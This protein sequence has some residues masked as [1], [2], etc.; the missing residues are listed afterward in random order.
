MPD[1]DQSSAFD[2]AP[3]AAAF[4]ASIDAVDSDAA[5]SRAAV[6]A[7][8]SAAGGGLRVVERRPLGEL[9]HVFSHIR[10][11]MRVERLVVQVGWC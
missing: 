11:T 3:T 1:P 5:D 10:M 9:V 8:A 7:A 6:A 4:A 2:A